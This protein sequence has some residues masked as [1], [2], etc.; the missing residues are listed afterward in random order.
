MLVAIKDKKLPGA[1]FAARAALLWAQNYVDH[2]WEVWNS[3]LT[4]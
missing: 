2:D 3:K 4:M 1:S